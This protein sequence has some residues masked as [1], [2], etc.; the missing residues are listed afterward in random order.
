M[1][2]FQK[3][4]N[5]EPA[6]G[7]EGDIASLNPLINYVTGPYGLISGASGVICGR[8][9]WTVDDLS[10]NN[11]ALLVAAGA[12]RTPSGF[13][14]NE[15]Q[16]LQ[17]VYLAESGMGIL[18]GQAME[19]F[20]RGDFWIKPKTT[21]TRGLKAF[22]NM[23][24]GTVYPAAAGA[25]VSASAITASFATN[26]MTVT[27][28][29]GV[30]AIGQAISGTGVPANTYIS[31]LGTGTGGTGTYNLSTSPGTVGSASGIVASNHIETRFQLLSAAAINEIAKI[32]LGD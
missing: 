7:V 12:A 6:P 27:V 31:S 21:A 29:S 4:V 18:P 3:Q 8:F 28:T 15:Q 32:G 19:L 9:G 13:I 5:Y 24:D 1:T 14:A 25:T 16:G 30:L 26:V 17:T 20:T 23:F 11:N 2:G 22:A 10:V